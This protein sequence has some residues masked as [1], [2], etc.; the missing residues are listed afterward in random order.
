[1]DE[2]LS[3]AWAGDLGLDV[4]A[5]FDHLVKGYRDCGT[6]RRHAARRCGCS[7][8][9]RPREAARRISIMA[10]V[11]L[12]GSP[13]AARTRRAAE[14]GATARARSHHGDRAAFFL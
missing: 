5:W 9:S 12:T 14:R 2:E 10:P 8:R 4:I 7:L 3:A 11:A 6:F 13:S 1:M